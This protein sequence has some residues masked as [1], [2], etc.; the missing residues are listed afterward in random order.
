MLNQATRRE[1]VWGIRGITASLSTSAL[2]GCGH[3]HAPAVL[4]P[5]KEP[6]PWSLCGNQSHSGYRG[7]QK[8]LSHLPRIEPRQS[9]P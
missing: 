3:L 4:P 1:D 8:N 6:F 5:G 7:E 2:E 9:N